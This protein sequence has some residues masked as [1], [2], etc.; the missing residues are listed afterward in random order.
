MNVGD[1]VKIHH[2]LERCTL[3]PQPKNLFKFL[4]SNLP[5]FNEG[6]IGTII[7]ISV[8]DNSTWF[9]ILSPAGMGWLRED[10]VLE[11]NF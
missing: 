5:K 2:D 10:Y 1:L 4:V 8:M 3:Y 11:V 9:K 6:E 7:E